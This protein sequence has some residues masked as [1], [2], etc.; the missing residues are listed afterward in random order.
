MSMPPDGA[1]IVSFTLRS[2]RGIG[3]PEV[4]V[5]VKSEP[6]HTED[7]E[8]SEAMPVTVGDHRV[9]HS[10]PTLRNSLREAFSGWTDIQRV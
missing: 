8:W 5:R 7:V 9:R 4:C 1:D 10:L 6:Y 3:Q 2:S